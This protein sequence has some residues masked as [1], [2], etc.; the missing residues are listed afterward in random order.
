[1]R[2]AIEI[3]QEHDGRWIA[4][5]PELPGVIAYGATQEDAIRNARV[6]AYRTVADRIE[7][8]DPVPAAALE[9]FAA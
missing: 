6:L 1:M 9:L 5:V 2:L 4:E 8:G 7:H 3:E